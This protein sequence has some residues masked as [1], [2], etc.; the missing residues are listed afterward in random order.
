M[1][2]CVRYVVAYQGGSGL[3]EQEKKKE[4]WIDTTETERKHKDE[5]WGTKTALQPANLIAVQK[6]HSQANHQ[7]KRKKNGNRE[8]RIALPE[9]TDKLCDDPPPHR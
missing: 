9:E 7:K 3:C 2:G 1:F 5:D 8:I 4:G 6:N